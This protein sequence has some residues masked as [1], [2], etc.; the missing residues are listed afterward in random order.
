VGAAIVAA[1]AI[2]V[3][4]LGGD[5][6]GEAGS[7]TVFESSDI[8][9]ADVT[10]SSAESSP[11]TAPPEAAALCDPGAGERCITIDSTRLEDDELVIEWTALGFDASVDEFHAHFFLSDIN[12]AQAGSNAPDFGFEPGYWELTDEQPYRPSTLLDAAS[13]GPWLVDFDGLGF[14][15]GL[16][17]TVGTAPSH[18]V[19]NPNLFT[20][21]PLPA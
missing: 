11:T 15:P 9:P 18:N 8:S 3:V 21:T 17:V 1:V 20:C 14:V 2:G 5:D 10:T 6:D 13:G 19:L 4:A 12:A 7:T 16:C